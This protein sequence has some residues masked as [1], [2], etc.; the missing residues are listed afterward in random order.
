MRIAG[1]GNG[2]RT[3]ANGQIVGFVTVNHPNQPDQD[4][5]FLYTN[6]SL[7]QIP[8][9]AGGGYFY[10]YAYGLSSRSSPL[11]ATVE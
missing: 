2:P 4:R 1:L 10:S 9:P 7:A 11:A 8:L 6:G 5:A 3:N